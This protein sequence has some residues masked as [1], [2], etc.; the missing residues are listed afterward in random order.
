MTTQK[1][2]CIIGGGPKGIAVAVKAS[3]LRRL[4][5]DA[6]DVRII[7]AG[8][9]AHHW[10]RRGGW[11][12]GRQSLG[13]SPLK[14]I[15]F[16]YSTELLADG[17]ALDEVMFEVS[18]P[19][20]LAKNRTFA[21]WTDRGAPSPSHRE[22]A[23]YL[24]WAATEAGVSVVHG[25][26][27]SVDRGV[28]GAFDIAVAGEERVVGD[29]V[30]FTGF[31]HSGRKL[32]PHCISVGEFWLD[33][34]KEERFEDTRVLVIGSGETSAS[35]TKCIIEMSH[36]ADLAVVSP[37]ETIYSRGESF[38]ENRLYSDPSPWP[39]MSEGQR[40]DFIRRTDR[41]VFSQDVQSLI[42]TRG[43]HRHVQGRVEAVTARS[44]AFVAEIRSTATGELVAVEADH[45]IDARGGN[46]LWF[47][48]L[49]TPALRED[50]AARCGSDL[51][52]PALEQ[53]IG[54]DLSLIGYPSKVF[55]P[56]LAALR[57]GP[58]FPNLSS[59]GL[60][61]DRVLSGLAVGEQGAPEMSAV[62]EQ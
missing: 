20:Y 44:A 19:A 56:N 55:V 14:D 49:L 25:E 42:S 52:A 22:W 50:I 51:T 30:M 46:P 1:R 23:A 60:L 28:D 11:T 29:A 38:L 12:D 26:A 17:R 16:P 57:Q 27:V 47:V 6:P 3:V 2:L 36:P 61:S 7:E 34:S 59:L 24:E 33:K 39:G 15:G 21:K 31:G 35:I 45:V 13:T 18:W 58:G 9:I 8:R 41:A 43:V 10:R 5:V 53:R 48:D 4:G 62:A 37:T 40:R 32:S 54:H